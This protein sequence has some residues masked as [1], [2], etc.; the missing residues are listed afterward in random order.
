MLHCRR[1]K[2]YRPWR[3]AGFRPSYIEQLILPGLQAKLPFLGK[4]IE[5]TGEPTTPKDSKETYY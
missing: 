5:K 3:T 4:V 1:G 2:F